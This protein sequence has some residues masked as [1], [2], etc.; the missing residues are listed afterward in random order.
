[1]DAEVG[2]ILDRLERDGLADDTIV[3]FF[4]DHGSGMPRSKRWLYDTSL[5]VPLLVRFPPNYADLAPDQAGSA[6]DRLVSFVDFAPTMLSLAGIEPPARLQGEAF[7]G[8]HQTEPRQF[9]FGFRDRMDERTD[10]LRAVRG[11]R[12]KY[13]RNWRP[14]LPWF[15]EQQVSY[16]YQMPTMQVWQR[17][18]DAGELNDVQAV[19]M[20]RQKPIEEL[21]DTWNDPWEIHNLVSDAAH[22]VTLERLRTVADAWSLEIV[23]LG[24]LPEA[25]LRARFGECPAYE[26]ARIDLSSYPL[27]RIQRVAWLAARHDPDAEA[28]LSFVEDND[29][30]VRFWV[31]CGLGQLETP[32]RD[33]L[34]SL[35]T[36]LAD[37]APSV[38]VAAA[39]S[40]LRQN[41][42]TV[43]VRTTLEATLA[44]NNPWARL[45]TAEVVDRLRPSTW[46][47]RELLRVAE[48]D[49]NEYVVR[50]VESARKKP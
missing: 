22:E 47:I 41:H 24:F 14:W 15:H 33:V 4:S 20:A 25:D 29:P 19:F 43:E 28:L 36:L 49:S 1:M 9:V 8:A 44:D 10:M 50:I 38:R 6:N 5:H 46:D 37:E 45:Q 48:D 31:A 7:L 42:V 12:Y 18:A 16:M 23:D 2:D 34:T 17:L 26:A 30:A 13:I 11:E 32:R 35:R 39:E 27:E 21:Y 3:F 40:L